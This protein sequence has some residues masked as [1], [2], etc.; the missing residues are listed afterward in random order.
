MSSNT[1]CVRK[2]KRILPKVAV[3]EIWHEDK[4]TDKID[5]I[6]LEFC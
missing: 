6:L 1:E 2:Y 5:N 3:D 4:Y